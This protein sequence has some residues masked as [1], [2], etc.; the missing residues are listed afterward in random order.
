MVNVM[1]EIFSLWP[2]VKWCWY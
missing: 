1:R 2:Q